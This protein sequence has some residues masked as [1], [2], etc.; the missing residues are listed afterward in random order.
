MRLQEVPRADTPVAE[1]GLVRRKPGIT[2][3]AADSVI[4]ELDVSRLKL[5]QQF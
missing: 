5:N 3:A 1:L 2:R 4:S